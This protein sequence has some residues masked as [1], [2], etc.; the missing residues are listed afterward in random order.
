M[1]EISQFNIDKLV[2]AVRGISRQEARKAA[3]EYRTTTMGTVSRIENDG[4][5]WVNLAG[6][7]EETPVTV[8]SVEVKEGEQVSVLVRNGYATITGN[9]SN[10]SVGAEQV[11]A[12]GESVVRVEK[13][14]DSVRTA[15][16]DADRVLARE[17]EADHATLG[18]LDVNYA[19]IDAA[20]IQNETVRNSWID[21]LMVQTGL[22]AN[23]G[24]IF[25]LDAIQ[26]NA[27]NIT[28]GTIDVDR[29]IVTVNGEKYLVH[30]DP[31]TSYPTYQKLDGGVIEDLTI[32]ADK[33]V[34]GSVTA[35]KI[36][37]ENL[38]GT[39]GWINL[40]NGTF[41]YANAQTGDGIS[42][43]GQ[44]LQIGAAASIAGMSVEDICNAANQVVYDHSYTYDPVTEIYSFTASVNKGG[45]DVT[46]S[47]HDDFFIWYLKTE[48]GTSFLGRGKTMDVPAA[49]A[50]YSGAV[51]G[52]LEDYLDYTLADDTDAVIQT[53]SG[54][55]ISMRVYGTLQV[56]SDHPIVDSTDSSVISG[57]N[58]NMYAHVIW[59]V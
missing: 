38:V 23:E 36:T 2:D 29:L 32:T 28:A 13:Y 39:G 15:L 52:A 58:D 24:T 12:V 45:V 50:I 42:W 10:P 46:E 48:N 21:Q 27:S 16:V 18:T 30:V 51:L 47:Y 37:A 22:L 43:D 7:D 3:S 40:A 25:T 57:T 1:S 33:L 8:S 19:R 55:F 26:V 34:A 44:H 4:V 5:V 41:S 14:V 35:E 6:S 11:Q 56:R 49:S 54:D 17:I 59:E 53:N 20:N 31:M 9:V